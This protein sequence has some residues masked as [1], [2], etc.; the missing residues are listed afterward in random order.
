MLLN[1]GRKKSY[2]FREIARMVI[3]TAIQ[4]IT[5][6]GHISAVLNL[7][8]RLELGIALRLF[9]YVG[10]GYSSLSLPFPSRQHRMPLPFPS[11]TQSVRALPT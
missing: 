6:Y 11:V 10:T 8:I 7:A 5:L 1:W 4:P 3:A 9:F 2:L